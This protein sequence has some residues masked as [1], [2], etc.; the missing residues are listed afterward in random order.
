MNTHLA[1]IIL[2]ILWPVV[3]TLL[4][5]F[6]ALLLVIVWPLLLTP[7]VNLDGRT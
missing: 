2:F 7:L 6:I 4:L 3:A 1:K 5:L